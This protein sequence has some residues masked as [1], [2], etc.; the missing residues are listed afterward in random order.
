MSIQQDSPAIGRCYKKANA[1]YAFALRSMFATTFFRDV[2]A[3]LIEQ[4]PSAYQLLGERMKSLGSLSCG[5]SFLGQLLLA[6]SRGR[7][8]AEVMDIARPGR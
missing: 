7:G 6:S 5:V 4:T 8:V 1:G 2:V 3:D